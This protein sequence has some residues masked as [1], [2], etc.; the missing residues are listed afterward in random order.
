MCPR[1]IGLLLIAWFLLFQKSC[2]LL[3]EVHRISFRESKRSSDLLWRPMQYPP[4]NGN[5]LEFFGE[6]V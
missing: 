4:A 6:R 5:P 3:T 1:S 2:N